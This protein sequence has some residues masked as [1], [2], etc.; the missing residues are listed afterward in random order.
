MLNR[1]TRAAEGFEVGFT[2][3]TN[4]PAVIAGKRFFWD[5]PSRRMPDVTAEVSTVVP[6]GKRPQLQ[7]TLTGSYA[8]DATTS[9]IVGGGSLSDGRPKADGVVGFD[10]RIGRF[11]VQPL[12][13]LRH[14]GFHA[15]LVALF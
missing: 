4:A 7:A 12:H 5:V 9:V 10:I 11:H 2:T 8:L 13:W 14:D 15:N 1:R 6:V 3:V